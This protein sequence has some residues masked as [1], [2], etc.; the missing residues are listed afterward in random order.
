M[1]LQSSALAKPSLHWRELLK[2]FLA[3]LLIGIIFSK[4][5]LSQIIEVFKQISWTW[6]FISFALFFLTMAL[7]GLQYWALF[8]CKI[9]YLEVVKIVVLQNAFSNLVTNTAGVATYF[10][11]FRV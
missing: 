2:I 6:F 3:F 8:E 5:S 9:P 4:T 1:K 11:L 10:T 7:K